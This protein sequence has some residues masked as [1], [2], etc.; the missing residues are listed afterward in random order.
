M[1]SIRN[2]G[3][4][5]PKKRET[6]L[7]SSA[8]ETWRSPAEGRL[9]VRS[10]CRASG[11]TAAGSYVKLVSR[12]AQA[13]RIGLPVNTPRAEFAAVVLSFWGGFFSSQNRRSR[14]LEERAGY[15]FRVEGAMECAHTL[16]R[17]ILL[18]AV[19]ALAPS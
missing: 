10:D 19:P 2:I 18:P 16:P 6:R 13:L 1:R 17:G 11:G 7:S 9:G 3:E 8:C 4:N 15:A 5:G 12:L 14:P